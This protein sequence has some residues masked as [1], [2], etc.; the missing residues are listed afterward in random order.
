M[1]SLDDLVARQNIHVQGLPAAPSKKLVAGPD[2]NAVL[3]P[4]N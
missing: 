4:P 2:D 3:R 1:P